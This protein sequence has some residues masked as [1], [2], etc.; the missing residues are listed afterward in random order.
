MVATEVTMS[1]QTK[2]RRFTL[3][4]Y[5]RMGTSGILGVDDR[6]ELVAGDVVE[7]WPVDSRHAGTVARLCHLFS[8]RLGGRALVWSQ[9]PL[10]LRG[11]ESQPQPD[12]VLLAPRADFYAGGLP[13]PPSVRLLIEVADDSLYFDRQ[14][15]LPI[16][17]KAGVTESWL[18]KLD[19]HRLEIHR[20]PGRLRYRSVRLPTPTETFAPVAFPDLKLTARDLFG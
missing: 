1:V 3:D 2:R 9:N 6:V 15:K 4:Q 5:R 8:T 11:Y 16:Y 7:L 13:E 10:L 17:A 20:N 18:V 12:L 19:A 14:K